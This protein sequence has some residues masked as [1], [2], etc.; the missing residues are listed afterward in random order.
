M[1][2]DVTPLVGYKLYKIVVC[3]LTLKGY[4]MENGDYLY[5][6]VRYNLSH[7]VFNAAMCS[8]SGLGVKAYTRPA[9]GKPKQ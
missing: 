8:F 4:A 2:V 1:R 6:T 7:I 5:S 3:G 9:C